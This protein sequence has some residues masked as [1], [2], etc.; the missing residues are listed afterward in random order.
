MIA[1][2][3]DR[4]WAKKLSLA[5][6]QTLEKRWR[7]RWDFAV[8]RIEPGERVLDVACGDGVL[9]EMLIRTKNCS[10]TGLDVSA[11]ARGIAARRGVEVLACDISE[12]RFPVDDSAFDAATLLCCLEHVF[13]PGHALREASRAVRVGGRLLVTLPN[14]VSLR[15]RLDF[16]RGRLS[17]DLLHTNDGE[18]LHIRFFNYA[19]DF[20]R[21]VEREAPGLRLAEKV[22]A[23]KNPKRHGPVGRAVLGA[24]MRLWP[25]LF[26]EYTHYTLVRA[27]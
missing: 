11:H 3:Y 25:N 12:E 4:V 19:A 5:H 23:L 7:S 1:D 14:A 9:G 21:F 27:G 15:F 17:K 20:D 18:G 22:P 6:Y 10:V 2:Y 13:D 26:A 16:L 8:E 24:G